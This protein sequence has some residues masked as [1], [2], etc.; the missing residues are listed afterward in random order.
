[1]NQIRI[2]TIALFC[3][4]FTGC[5]EGELTYTVNPNGSAKLRLEIVTD[6]AAVIAGQPRP[7]TDEKPQNVTVDGLLR[8]SLRPILE[9]PQV[10]AWKDVSAEFLPY[11]KLKFSGTA[12]LRQVSDF[13]RQGSV[14]MLIPEL[15]IERTP[16][17][18]MKL[19]RSASSDPNSQRNPKKQKPKTPEEIKK[20][21]DAEL[22]AEILHD[23]VQVQGVKGMLTAILLDS[24]IKGV[25]LMPGDVTEAVGFAH[26]GRKASYTLDGNKILAELNKTL[27]EDRASLRKFYRSATT[28][29]HFK[30]KILGEQASD[31]FITVA[32]PGEP[33]FDFE[34]ELM[35]ARAAYPD[36]RKK[37]GFGD[38]LKLPTGD[39]QPK[40]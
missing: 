4:I 9:N 39:G 2:A 5:V 27:A 24:K 29:D 22:D 10:A 13:A 16:Q 12:Y 1:M 7:T 37:F 3:L 15:K 17:G 23:F 40:K 28:P 35:E 11:G 18:A 25:F 31:G 14:P 34:K 26:E 38:D 6:T 36:L 33:L 30:K 21:T 19:S 20:L 8:D 32:K